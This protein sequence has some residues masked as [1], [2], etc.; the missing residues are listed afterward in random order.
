MLKLNLRDKV[1]MKTKSYCASLVLLSST[2]LYATSGGIY[3][4]K[5]GDNLNL[6]LNR[7]IDY[8]VGPSKNALYLDILK[9]NQF[10][11]NPNLIY[12]GQSLVLPDLHDVVY[13]VES[14]DTISGIV[15]KYKHLAPH[16]S[17]GNQL[18]RT[19][20]ANPHIK[21]PDLIEVGD[22]IVL[23][24][25]IKPTTRKDFAFY[26]VKEGESV[27]E[28]FSRYYSGVDINQ[29]LNYVKAFNPE[30]K[31]F[32][33]IKP[34]Q[35]IK[36]PST[37][38]AKDLIGKYVDRAVASVKSI[39]PEYFYADELGFEIRKMDS[40]EAKEYID[41]FQKLT[42]TDS[43]DKWKRIFKD[44]VE[45]SSSEKHSN[46]ERAFYLYSID[47]EEDG[48]IARA[49]DEVKKFLKVWKGARERRLKL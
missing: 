16:L 24:K 22:R 21:D 30:I 10:I 9:Y 3:K 45:R 32:T 1:I 5:E 6:I 13:K 33:D 11:K 26:K 31:S 25:V 7:F 44:I 2:S 18:R 15:Q 46:I 49:R 34:N 12:P 38:H 47:I 28:I 23:G 8:R 48:D 19:I 43:P 14:G 40:D 39:Q 36:L 41:H 4:V 20:A 42:K 29:A 37:K 35:S 27:K 17:L